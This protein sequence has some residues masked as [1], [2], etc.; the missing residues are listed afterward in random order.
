MQR[1]AYF[2]QFEL[3]AEKRP[4]KVAV[5]MEDTRISYGEL[6]ND[7]ALMPVP[8]EPSLKDPSEFRIVGQSLPDVDLDAILTGKQVYS[9]DLMLPD[10]LYAVVKRCPVGDGQP[11]SYDDTETRR[12]AGVVGCQLL[13]NIDHGGRII[14][15]NCPNFVSGVAVLATSTWAATNTAKDSVATNSTCA[16][17]NHSADSR[18]V[19]TRPNRSLSHPDGTSAITTAR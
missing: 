14:L 6:A 12:V 15:P 16:I 11:A 13:R 5:E 10:I 8:G 4:E 2:E 9:A 3:H 7:A 18:R 17:S 19:R 1:Q